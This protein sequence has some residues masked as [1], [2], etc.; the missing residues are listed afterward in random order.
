M[1]RRIVLTA[2]LLLLVPLAAAAATVNLPKTGQTLCYDPSGPID[3]ANTGQDGETQ[4]GAD[5][6][7]P[8]FTDNLNGTVTD[9][10][11]GLIWLKDA[12]CAAINPPPPNPAQSLQGGWN[13]T[14]ALAAAKSLRS[15]Q[16][17]LSDGSLPGTW[18][19]PN[20]NEFESLMDLS[21]AN[22]PLP[23]NHPFTNLPYPWPIY[24]TST[25]TAD[26]FPGINAIGADMYTGTIQGDAKVN[27]KYI[28]PVKGDSTTLARTGQHGCWDA[29]GNDTPCNGSGS[30]GDLQ[31]GVPM[32]Y[33]RFYDNGNG[34]TTDALTGL[35]WPR[36]AGCF[37]N[38]SSQRQAISFAQNLANGE[39]DLND[40]SVP[41]DWRLPNRKEMRSLVD[42][43]GGWLREFVNAPNHGWYWT[44]DSFPVPSYTSDKWMVKS[45]G[46]DWL[47]STLLTY[48]QLPPY[49]ALPVRGPLI[50]Q[51]ITFNAPATI[52]YG[53]P[54][55]NLSTIT[56]GGGSGNPVTFNLVSGPATLTETTL[57]FTGGG[58]VVVTAAQAGNAQYYPAAATP[59][60]FVVESSSGT[61]A[62]TTGDLTRTYDGTPKPV[63]ATTS[64][65]G[66]PVT[67]SYA[68]SA[69]PPTNAGSYLVEATI[70]DPVHPGS[71]RATLVI[72]KAT[73][74]LTLGGLNQTYDGT[75]RRPTATTVPAGGNVI[76]SY[77]GRTTPP[78][79]AG[80]YPIVATISDPNFL[81]TSAS[82]TLTIAKA[83]GTVTLGS[84][85]PVYDGTVQ[86]ATA[87]TNPTGLAVIFSYTP[88]NPAAAGNYAVVG[89]IAD[90]NYLGSASGTMTIAKAP[91]TV[92][93][94]NLTQVSD[95]TLKAATVVT[96]PAGLTVIFSYTP[97]NP[98]GVGTYAVVGTIADANYVGSASGTLTLTAP[99]VATFLV[100][101]TVLSGNG[102][103]SCTS[104]VNAGA[105]AACTVTSA[106]GYHPSALTDNGADRLSA[107]SGDTYSISGV[108]ANHAVVVQFIR[109]D[110][111]LDPA[112]GKTG[113][114]IG[115]AL[116]VL[117][118]V[119]G[120][121]E[122][123]S[124][125]LAHA[126]IAPLGSDGKPSGDGNLDIYDVIG[127]LRMVVGL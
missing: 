59:H 48:Q 70:T 31:K 93:L 3:C 77:T 117:N 76:F 23:A 99:A 85:S 84:L 17:G 73:G 66:L 74:T 33:P 96:H 52:R 39:C 124:V 68:G 87:V 37:S 107:L 123:T 104:P 43:V 125:G 80:S 79:A 119:H 75:E 9:N 64:P 113:P 106:A 19:V 98:V 14:A 63:T 116:A 97:V 49:F 46:L 1:T 94:G 82:G 51:R 22:P 35:I 102:S 44:S 21:Q 60:T 127:I 100:T 11:T 78:S 83:S 62:I 18:R 50:I 71:A 56:T 115:D 45:Q 8:R 20:V 10:L 54:P 72:G 118:M 42:Y 41:G 95:G 30:D 2:W 61:V 65:P 111:I 89:T 103:I 88:A 28:W 6:P 91:G 67:L 29:D 92:T 53:D 5:W 105:S 112:N 12:V 25:I 26:Y 114:D 36:N 15:G 86:A 13:W 38:I 57:T 81:A 47:A 34:T 4:I 101:G 121:S 122:T 110:G 126:D 109:P 7:S 24:W 69:S 90:P 120:G 16:C 55:L 32:P 27:L 108:T 40:R 58:N